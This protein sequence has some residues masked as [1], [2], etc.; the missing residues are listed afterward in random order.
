VELVAGKLNRYCCGLCY[1]TVQSDMVLLELM[2]VVH[3]AMCWA[4][5]QCREVW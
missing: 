4:G 5:I 3:R 2:E 1:G